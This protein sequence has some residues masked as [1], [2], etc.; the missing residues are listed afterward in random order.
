MYLCV[1]L[2]FFSLLSSLD[3]MSFILL[4]QIHFTDKYREP[5][6]G[7][8]YSREGSPQDTLISRCEVSQND[9]VGWGLYPCPTWQV[10]LSIAGYY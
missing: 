7:V 10:G 8:Y 4:L 9:T 6:Y 2:V 5:G 3:V 1:E